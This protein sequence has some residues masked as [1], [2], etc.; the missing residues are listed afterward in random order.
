MAVDFAGTGVSTV[1]IWMGILLT[2]RMR[3]AFDGRPD[4]LASFAEHTETLI[5]PVGSS[6]PCTA[7]RTCRRCRGTPSSVP[8]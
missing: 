7:I 5:P 2:E 4:A 3:S 6:T 8:K 1:S